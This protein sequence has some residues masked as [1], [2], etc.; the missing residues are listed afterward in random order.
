MSDKTEKMD[1]A[2]E[3]MDEINDLELNEKELNNIAAGSDH[4]ACCTG[5]TEAGPQP[6]SRDTLCGESS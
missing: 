5:E 3:L 2:K 6:V 1:K 4:C